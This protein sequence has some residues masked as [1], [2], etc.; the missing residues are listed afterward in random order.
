MD[1]K[2]AIEK[3]KEIIHV[4]ETNIKQLKVSSEGNLL[5]AVACLIQALEHQKAIVLLSSINLY[6]SAHTLARPMIEAFYKGVWL[7][8]CAS[9]K[10]AEEY[11][12]DNLKKNTK[13]LLADIEKCEGFEGGLISDKK[14]EYWR[15]MGGFVHCGSYQMRRQIGE[16][17]FEPS[18]SIEEKLCL[19]STADFF[20]LM[21][22]GQIAFFAGEKD[23]ETKFLGLC[24]VAN[25]FSTC[26]AKK[27][28]PP[29]RSPE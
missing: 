23:I 15:V 19:I 18:F 14:K 10:E 16:G 22:A 8:R 26:V 21:A 29:D 17:I 5:I 7:G 20:G 25:E 2:R 12:K 13:S 11:L 4:I 1:T 3:S 27:S 28:P 24:D 9:E 6:G